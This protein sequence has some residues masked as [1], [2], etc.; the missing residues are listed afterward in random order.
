[1]VQIDAEEPLGNGVAEYSGTPG[2]VAT[3][4]PLALQPARVRLLNPDGPVAPDNPALPFARAGLAPESASAPALRALA[5]AYG[6]I[7]FYAAAAT[8]ASEP[9]D[10]SSR[11][12]MRLLEAAA[13][14]TRAA[15]AAQPA[16]LPDTELA[17]I[18]G[19]LWQEIAALDPRA[20]PARDLGFAL[21]EP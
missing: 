21:E 7:P 15:I 3:S 12:I 1:M 10:T 4:L 5:L 11:N 19:N 18:W 13:A 17:T 16:G 9:G 6:G 20:A 8:R 14:R 2:I